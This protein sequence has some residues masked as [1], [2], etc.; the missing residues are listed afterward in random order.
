MIGLE[1]GSR[2]HR[3][4]TVLGV[5]AVFIGALAVGR[6]AVDELSDTDAADAPFTTHAAVSDGAVSLSYMDVEVTGV[7]AT[8]TLVE[9]SS[10]ETTTATFLV[11]D[12][13]M[14]ATERSLHISGLRLVGGDGRV[15]RASGVSRTGCSDT[16]AAPTGVRVFW[17]A[18]F[19]VPDEAI[20]GAAL[21]IGRG[22]PD[23][24]LDRRDERAEIDLELDA[25]QARELAAATDPLP[26]VS[27]GIEPYDT[28]PVEEE[29]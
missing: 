13:E 15:Y 2:T 9:S 19:E 23:S 29:R 27:R 24:G 25:P 17:M 28:L 6:I 12:M 5:V 14:L 22:N 21:R 4:L 8:D 16:S 1:R 3:L 7:R 26:A 20:E 11:V 18:C 10:S